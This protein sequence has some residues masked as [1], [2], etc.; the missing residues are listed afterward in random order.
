MKMK[1]L[2]GKGPLQADK[3]VPLVFET[4]GGFSEE[5]IS[6][7]QLVG[8]ESSGRGVSAWEIVQG[9]T[10]EVAIAIQRGNAAAILNCLD[11]GVVKAVP[12]AVAPAE[13]APSASASSSDA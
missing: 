7:I 9:L 4:F 12:A 3:F 10:N 11:Q 2:I 6:F 5:T 13:A 1:K 8:K